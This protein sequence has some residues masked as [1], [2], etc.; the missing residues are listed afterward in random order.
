VELLSYL[1]QVCL[2]AGLLKGAGDLT[3]ATGLFKK[4]R[5]EHPAFAADIPHVAH[6]DR[7]L[8]GMAMA[9]D[10]LGTIRNQGTMSHPNQTLLEKPEALLAINA[11]RTILH[12]I[13]LRIKMQG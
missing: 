2:D 8:G 11:G 1:Q 12:Y 6:S 9:L 4:L 5:A 13:D 7:I 10:V 3:T